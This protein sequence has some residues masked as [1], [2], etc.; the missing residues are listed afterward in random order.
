MGCC[1]KDVQ[2]M[3]FQK[4]SDFM[5]TNTRSPCNFIFRCL[6]SRLWYSSKNSALVSTEIF[7]YNWSGIRVFPKPNWLYVG[8]FRYFEEFPLHPSKLIGSVSEV[9][10]FNRLVLNNQFLYH[11]VPPEWSCNLFVN[12]C[13]MWLMYVWM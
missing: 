7:G 12:W 11:R 13:F 3:R 6:H 4:K 9:L 2:V 10:N 1:F 8:I 5:C